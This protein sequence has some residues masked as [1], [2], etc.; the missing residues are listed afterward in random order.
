MVLP[1]RQVFAVAGNFNAHFNANVNARAVALNRRG[2]VSAG[3]PCV[4]DWN[5]DLYKREARAGSTHERT[6]H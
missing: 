1:A 5:A 2:R 4:R 6:S 3:V